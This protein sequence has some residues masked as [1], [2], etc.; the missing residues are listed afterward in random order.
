MASLKE[1]KSRI[2][3][4]TSTR[5]ITSAMKMVA[6]AKL[7]K[8]QDGIMKIRPYS[9]KLSDVLKKVSSGLDTKHCSVYSQNRDVNNVLI[10]LLASNRGLCGAFNNTVSK[11]AVDYAEDCYHKQV[12][13]G[14]VKFVC[15]GN[16]ATEFMKKQKYEII[17]SEA[18]IFENLTFKNSTEIADFVMKSFVDKTFDRVDIIYN[19]FKNA[20]VYEQRCEQFLPMSIT[21]DEADDN[22]F[23]YIFEPNVEKIV[24]EMIPKSLKIQF[25]RNLMDSFAAEQGARM[26]AMHQATDN[27]TELIKDL[28]LMYNKARQASITNELIEI[29]SGAEALVGR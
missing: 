11:K 9:N 3:S 16:K 12:A 21:K 14:K 29:T 24:E 22:S 19:S 5:Q 17:K 1:I 26:T 15:I 27:A 23:D 4:I 13:Q 6:V 7:K 20:A 10:I 2:S 28:T 18:D 25:Y 8:A